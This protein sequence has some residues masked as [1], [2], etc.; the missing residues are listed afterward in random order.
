MVG[1]CEAARPRR[2][3]LGFRQISGGNIPHAPNISRR[4]TY[5]RR[6]QFGNQF[7]RELQRV[8]TQ[9][10]PYKNFG[11][12]HSKTPTPIRVFARKVPCKPSRTPATQRL[13]RLS[14]IC[15][16]PCI[17]VCGNLGW[18]GN[19]TSKMTRP[20]QNTS[21]SGIIERRLP[22]RLARSSWRWCGEPMSKR[23][24]V[25]SRSYFFTITSPDKSCRIVAPP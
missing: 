7:G 3:P 19:P 12:E 22:L 6:T 21:R 11:L 10:A 24:I 5:V 9:A 4:T 14:E 18:R 13:N 2:D 20:Q 17:S 23:S 8:R 1:C 25:T 15:L 16:T